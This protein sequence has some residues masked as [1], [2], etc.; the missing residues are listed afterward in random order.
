MYPTLWASAV[1]KDFHWQWEKLS[2]SNQNPPL[3]AKKREHVS[4]GG[5][6]EFGQEG[7]SRKTWARVW[8]LGIVCRQTSAYFFRW[9]H[10]MQPN[11][12][13]GGGLGRLVSNNS[14][15]DHCALPATYK[16]SASHSGV[17]FC[18][19][20]HQERGSEHPSESVW[21]SD[22]PGVICED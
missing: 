18:H 13:E 8:R 1:F 17:T 5:R 11:C 21:F 10:G 22:S 2:K 4:L 15:F 3:Q 20:P 12:G 7:F 14:Y 16:L 6:A 19:R 9:A